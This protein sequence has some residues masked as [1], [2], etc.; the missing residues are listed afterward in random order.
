VEGYGF[1]VMFSDSEMELG[2]VGDGAMETGIT[3]SHVESYRLS[4]WR[5]REVEFVDK[6]GVDKR[7]L[8]T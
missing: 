6:G 2:G 1:V 5:G 8:S 4:K 3:V 7:F